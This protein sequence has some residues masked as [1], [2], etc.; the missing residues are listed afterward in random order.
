MAPSAETLIETGIPVWHAVLELA[1]DESKKTFLATRDTE[2]E[3]NLSGYVHA[4]TF[5]G[6]VV[7]VPYQVAVSGPPDN[8]IL[9]LDEEDMRLHGASAAHKLI[10]RFGTK[11]YQ[12]LDKMQQLG[13]YND[14]G[15]GIMEAVTLMGACASHMK[16]NKQ[17]EIVAATGDQENRIF[18]PPLEALQ[19]GEPTEEIHRLYNSPDKGNGRWM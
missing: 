10:M 12:Q 13:G 5:E 4:K 19:R 8:I 18:I 7:P 2:S 6:S 11:G 14:V 3:I 1:H 17:N 9:A 16:Q 15:S